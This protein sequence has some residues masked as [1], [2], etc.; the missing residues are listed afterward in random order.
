MRFVPTKYII[1]HRRGSRFFY[2]WK[3]VDEGGIHRG[4][5]DGH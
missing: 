3:D 4:E 1:H 5:N 2:R